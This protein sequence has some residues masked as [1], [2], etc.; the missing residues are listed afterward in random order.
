MELA[1]SYENPRSQEEARK[2]VPFKEL[3]NSAREKLSLIPGNNEKMFWRMYLEEV[4][5]WF[6]TKFFTWFDGIDCDICN[7]PMESSGLKVATAQ[8]LADGA[9]RVERYAFFHVFSFNCAVLSLLL[10]H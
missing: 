6:K 1:K 8:Q 9:S 5:R 4:T 7:K 3:E 2:L 10:G